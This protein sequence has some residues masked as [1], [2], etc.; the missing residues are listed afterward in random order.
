MRIRDWA[1]SARTLTAV[2]AGAMAF[3]LLGASPAS[4]HYVYQEGEVYRSNDLCTNVRAEISHGDG[5]GYARVDAKSYTVLATPWG[6]Y[7]CAKTHDRPGGYIAAKIEVYAW[8]GSAW[9][10]CAYTDWA[11]NSGSTNQWI[12]EAWMSGLPYCGTGWYGTMGTGYVW[13]NNWFGGSVW[14]GHHWLPDY[15]LSAAEAPA[16]FPSEGDTVGVLDAAGEPVLNPDGTPATAVVGGPPPAPDNSIQGDTP[17]NSIQSEDGTV[18]LR[19]ASD[20]THS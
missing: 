11:Y 9:Y 8:N 19:P 16:A 1:R 10:L 4:A 13:N 20:L 12:I 7:P 18:E 15:S 6:A 17:E 2:A 5:G 14:S 3:V